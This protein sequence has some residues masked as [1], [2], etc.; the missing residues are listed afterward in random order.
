MN[1]NDYREFSGR[2]LVQATAIYDLARAAE[3]ITRHKTDDRNTQEGPYLEHQ[4][5]QLN[6]ASGYILRVSIEMNAAI[7]IYYTDDVYSAPKSLGNSVLANMPELTELNGSR[8]TPYIA[9]TCIIEQ[10]EILKKFLISIGAPF[11]MAALKKQKI[12]MDDQIYQRLLNLINRRNELTHD[13]VFKLP[14][15]KEAVE[16]AHSCRFIAKQFSVSSEANKAVE[17]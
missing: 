9:K 16:F 14:D 2:S 11:S 13:L 3:R 17:G 4:D 10:F 7:N 8:V 12:N 6:D 5:M 1:H 15:M